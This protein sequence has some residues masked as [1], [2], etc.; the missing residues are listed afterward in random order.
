MSRVDLHNHLL[1]GLDD[2]ARD[3]AESLVLARA[4]ASAGWSDIV[5]TPHARPDLDPDDALVATRLAEVQAAVNQ[6]GLALKL[7]HGRE[8]HLTPEFLVRVR[9]HQ[10][11]T[12][13]ASRWL[14]VELPFA[15]PVPGLANAMFEIRRAG[16]RTLIAHPERCAHFTSKPEAAREVVENG[17]RLQLELGSL[18]GLHGATAAR[19]A[20]TLL[21]EELVAVVATDLHHAPQ[22][23]DLLGRGL[24]ALR[25]EVGNDRLQRL[26]D[27]APRALLEGKS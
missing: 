21:E 11:R 1:F 4:L 25:R 15:A 6:E 12:L 20:R 7:H 24:E 3:L 5:V 18:A 9:A 26:T 14:L 8:H 23:D 19:V 13:G 2:G 22:A 27:T 17:G 10:V 16:Y